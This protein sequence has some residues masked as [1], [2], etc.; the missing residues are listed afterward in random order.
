MTYFKTN[1][2][3]TRWWWFSGEIPEVDIK[4]QLDW[5]KENNFGGVEIAFVYP[6]AGSKPGPQFLD[7]EF[8]S[9]VAFAKQYAESIG[10]GCDFTFGTLWPFCG[11]FISETDSSKTWQGP[12]LQRVTD[13]WEKAYTIEPARVL[14]HLSKDALLHYA[15]KIGTGLKKALSGAESAL[16]CDSWEVEMDKLWC[17][18]FEEKFKAKYNYDILPY[19][20]NLENDRTVYYDYF[21]MVAELVLNEFYLPYTEICHSLGAFS[22]V[23]CHG[24]PTDLLAAYASVDIP[25][26]EAILFDPEFSAIPSSAAA[27]SSKKEVSCET[28]TCLYGW[29]P[30]PGPPPHLKKEIITDLKLLADALFAN[31]INHIIYHGMPFNPIKENNNFYATVH[32]GWKGALSS[33]FNNFNIYL[34]KISGIM[35]KGKTYSQ[36]AVYLPFE[37]AVVS[38][39]LPE[40]LLKPSGYYAWEMHYNRFP[41]ELMGY[42][43]LWISGHFLEKAVAKDGYLII[44]DAR[45]SLLYI[46]VEYVDLKNLAE[47]LRLANE[48]VQ[49]C[50]KRKPI[51]PGKQKSPGYKKM[52]EELFLLPN[53]STKFSDILIEKPLI[54]GSNL[55]DFWCRQFTDELIIFFAH[56]HSKGL[57]YPMN[58]GHSLKQEKFSSDIRINLSNV[59]V[60]YH[61]EIE[62]FQSKLIRIN[63]FTGSTIEE[64][65][66]FD[67]N[68][69]KIKQLFDHS[70][71]QYMNVDS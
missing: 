30:R 60:L 47:I 4:F 70:K 57:T 71:T 34:E 15:E 19:L 39:K 17:K 1:K 63:K 53:V 3:Y 28:F 26:S 18:G 9:L 20:E 67:V 65:T 16:F 6:L 55:P 56:P 12:S 25:E 62:P 66:H 58:Y 22:R 38:G 29:V 68:I 2:P 7:T 31:G 14:D 36:M 33:E 8:S 23:Q 24:A 43:P 46:D 21:N 45:F 27:L 40:H 64:N 51:Q 35:K 41:E 10:L 48:G 37:D 52:A 13:T 69:E 44:G 49:I 11:T 32:V 5:L 59:S 61:L 50:L 54:E 42:R